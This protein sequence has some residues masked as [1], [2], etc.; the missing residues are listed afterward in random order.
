MDE[1]QYKLGLRACAAAVLVAYVY[2]L[3]EIFYKF[4]STKKI[5]NCAWE[6]GL[7]VLM[8]FIIIFVG[9]K[10]EAILLPK[11]VS[12]KEMPI[13][14]SK[15]YKRERIRNYIFNSIL[16]S[17][18]MVSISFVLPLIGKIP[19]DFY[20]PIADKDK[21]LNIVIN[22]SVEIIVLFF[23]SFVL[24]YSLGECHIRRYNKKLKDLEEN[25][26]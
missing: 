10:D 14:L 15:A 20:L 6:I 4:I 5:E 11:K 7:L 24:D 16:F 1:R 3:I 18:A 9:R 8:S 19:L 26:G 12:G 22:C 25:N 21:W 2:L 17:I 23:I 13:E